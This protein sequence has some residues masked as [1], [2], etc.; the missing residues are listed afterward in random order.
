MFCSSANDF[1]E[2]A[3]ELELSQLNLSSPLKSLLTQ[4]GQGSPSWGFHSY[5][6]LSVHS[7]KRAFDHISPD[8]VSFLS[9]FPEKGAPQTSDQVDSPMLDRI[10]EFLF[11]SKPV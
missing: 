6:S 10:E 3:Q 5:P 1:C 8:Q 2:V 4:D 11:S 9:S 7:T